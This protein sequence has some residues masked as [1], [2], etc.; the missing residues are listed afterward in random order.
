[1]L[2]E[3]ASV[4]CLKNAE[5]GSRTSEM[6]HATAADGNMLLVTSARA[7]VVAEFIIVAAE[8]LG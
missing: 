7:E 6:K 2:P 3:A 1:M 4:P 5:H 8:T